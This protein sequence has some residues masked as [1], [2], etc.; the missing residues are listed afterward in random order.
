MNYYELKALLES[1]IE[2]NYEK[3]SR[4]NLINLIKILVSESNYKKNKI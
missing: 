2:I 3:L 1:D 4:I